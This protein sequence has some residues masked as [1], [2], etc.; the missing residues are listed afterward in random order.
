LSSL[1]QER[2]SE[3]G[4]VPSMVKTPFA[5]FNSTLNSV[6]TRIG[7]EVDVDQTT[8]GPVTRVRHEI[9]TNFNATNRQTLETGTNGVVRA[10]GDVRGTVGKANVFANVSHVGR[11]G[12]TAEDGAT[13]STNVSKSFG[14]TARKVVKKVRQTAKN[15][16]A[17]H[18]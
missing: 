12:K 6:R 13:A 2:M 8:P 16:P 14:D 1:D 7:T 15:R 9:R 11:P 18:D 4:T 5:Q 3:I 10:Q 17:D